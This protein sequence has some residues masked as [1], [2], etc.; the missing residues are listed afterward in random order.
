MTILA[1]RRYQK[2]TE[3]SENLPFRAAIFYVQKWTPHILD[4]EF[5]SAAAIYVRL[6]ATIL[7]HPLHTPFS[8]SLLNRQKTHMLGSLFIITIAAFYVLLQMPIYKSH[9][10]GPL[11]AHITYVYIWLS[12][13]FHIEIA[14]SETEKYAR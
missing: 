2:I 4:E 3:I 14:K 8:M 9:Y 12:E 6:L 5:F 10:N 11:F 1:E 7:L 13:S